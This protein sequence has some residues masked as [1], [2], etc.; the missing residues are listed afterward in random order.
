MTI[1]HKYGIDYKE[2]VN[3]EFRKEVE[4]IIQELNLEVEAVRLADQDNH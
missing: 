1:E 2:Q 3:G 4:K